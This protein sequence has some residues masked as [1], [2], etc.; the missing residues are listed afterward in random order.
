[1][2]RSRMPRGERVID[3]SRPISTWSATA[4]RSR[5]RLSLDELAHLHTLPEHPDW[6]PYRTSYYDP[7][8][9][10]CLHPAPAR[11]TRRRRVRSLHR[12][13]ASPRASSPTAS[14]ILGESDDEILISAHVCHPSLANDNLSGIAVAAAPRAPAARCRRAG[15]RTVSSSRRGRS[16]HHLARAQSRTARR[17][18]T[19]GSRSTARGPGPIHLQAQPTRATPT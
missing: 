18:S 14:S 19:T 11:R 12:L 13:D 15:T 10:F 3:F 2:H 17:A 6:I 1:M 4:F 9:G 7:S 5:Q 16:G 8:W